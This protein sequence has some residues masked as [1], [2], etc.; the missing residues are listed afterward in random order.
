MG[1]FGQDRGLDS[2]VAENVRFRTRPGVPEKG[3]LD[4]LIHLKY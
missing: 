3:D 2:T 4:L 1:Q